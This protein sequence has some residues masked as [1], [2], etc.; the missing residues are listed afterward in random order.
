MN[1]NWKDRKPNFVV[2]KLVYILDRKPKAKAVSH[3]FESREYT[4][5]KGV[6][7]VR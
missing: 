4:G 1:K 5:L 6:R 2:G 7:G 3:E